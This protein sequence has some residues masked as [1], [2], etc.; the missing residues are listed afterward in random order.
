[1]VHHD[2]V[3]GSGELLVRNSEPDLNSKMKVELVSPALA[4]KEMVFC[5]NMMAELLF[6]E[7]F[8]AVP[9]KIDNTAALYVIRNRAY[10]CRTKRIGLKFF[11]IRGLVKQKTA[12]THYVSTQ[13]D[14]ANVRTKHLN[15]NRLQ[16]LLRKIKYS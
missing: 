4:M 6:N 14:L 1:M 7:D 2:V 8:K 11:Y 3:R 9:L 15:K 13:I 16:Q 10:S 12:A 5:S